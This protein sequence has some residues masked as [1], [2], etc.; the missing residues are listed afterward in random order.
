MVVEIVPR[1][2]AKPKKITTFLFYFS[3]ILLILTIAAYFGLYSV[4]D[5]KDQGLEDLRTR[6]AVQE[7]VELRN[8]KRDLM[9]HE[10]EIGDLSFLLDSYRE[11]TKFFEFIGTITH[12]KVMWSSLELDLL[13]ETVSLSGQA[14]SVTTLIQQIYIFEGESKIGD[15]ELSS[16]SVGDEEEVAFSV[17]FSL[18]PE[19]FK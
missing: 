4:K 3:L 15:F 16:F 1:P 8:L 17:V 2:K 5:K 18:A 12:P 11:P 14:D 19:L 7:T 6:L 9:K 10:E 13:E